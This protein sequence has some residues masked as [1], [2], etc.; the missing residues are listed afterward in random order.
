MKREFTPER[1]ENSRLRLLNDVIFAV[2]LC[3]LAIMANSV[4]SVLHGSVLSSWVW[5]FLATLRFERPLSY[6]DSGLRFAFVLLWL[7]SAAFVFLCVRLLSRTSFIRS[8]LLIVS[9][10]VAVAG[11]PIASGFTSFRGYLGMLSSIPKA[12][13]YAYAPFRWLGVE[14]I[15][16]L[17]GV[18][19]YA[20]SQ[21]FRSLR[22][23]LL[24]L[25]LHFALW[26]WLV[27][28][29]AGSGNILLWPGYSWIPLTHEHPSLIYPLLGL[30][31]SA[32]WLLCVRHAN[33][34]Q[35]PSLGKS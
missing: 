31:A 29:G 10:I 13:L 2:Y 25:V 8:L 19:L 3:L 34:S 32:V 14:M 24:L 22:F 26:S 9:G 35:Q 33:Q 16:S 11:F 30:L 20:F 18:F 23:G 21:W 15:A 7:G 17:V 12:L 4:R 6:E 1:T 5:R 28:L 27:I